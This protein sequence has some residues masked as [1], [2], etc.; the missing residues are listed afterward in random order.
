MKRTGI[1]INLM[2]F[3]SF[4]FSYAQEDYTKNLNG[5]SKVYIETGTKVKITAGSSNVLK[6]NNIGHNKTNNERAEGLKAV[7][8]GGADNTGFGFSM[9]QEGSVLRVKDLKSWMQRKDL[10]IELPKTIDIHID[11]G[12]LGSVTFEGFSSEIEVNS[13]VGNITFN[14]VTG[15]ITAH[16]ET[17]T[18]NVDFV[19][20]NQSSPI[21]VH[22]S[23]GSVDVSLPSNTKADL[24]LR[25]TM[26]TVYTDFELKTDAPD[27]MKVVGANRKIESKL[28]GGG[29][30]IVLRS[31]T[32]NV[33][34]RKK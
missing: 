24:E 2:A 5:I 23:T 3:L 31:S 28:N 8:S 16:S 19:N 17:G 34:L 11:C 12:N 33:Y 13:T 4:V 22:S 6:F 9:S 7:Y 30:N 26:G 27:G 20:V 29:V 32:G 1:I 14:D 25:S 15:P 18:I 21:T 10:Q